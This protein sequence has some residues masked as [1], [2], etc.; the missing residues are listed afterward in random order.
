[1]ESREITVINRAGKPLFCRMD[2]RV[3]GKKIPAVLVV[4]GF[5]GDSTQR[6]IQGISRTLNQKWVLTLRVDLTKNP[7]KSYLE[8]SDMTYAQELSD[9]EDVFDDFV[10]KCR[11]LI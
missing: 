3:P 10:K 8:F 1:M 6:H 11:R 4:H 2:G 9:I 5:K 7:G